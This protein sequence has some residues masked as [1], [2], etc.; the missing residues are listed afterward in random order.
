MS[1]KRPLSSGDIL[2]G[3][4]Q[5]QDMV[6]EKRGAAT[7]RATDMTLNRNVG[8]EM[9]PHSDERAAA[10]LEGARSSTRLTD[11]RFLRVL[12]IFDDE[13]GHSVVVR[14]W[15]RAFPLDQL[16]IQSPLPNRRAATVVSE[17]AEAVAHAHELGV[18]HGALSPHGVLLK[19]SGAVRVTGLGTAS[20]LA[21]VVAEP[22]TTG[23]RVAEQRDVEALGKLLYACLTG[24]WP[25]EA[26]DGLRMAPTEHG[27]LLRPRQVRAGVSRDVDA[28]CD[29]ILGSPPRNHQA[30]LSS[31]SSIA[32]TLRLAGED[33]AVL[34]DENP[35]LAGVSSPDLL[36]LDPV[37][38]PVG[39]PP[40]INPPRRRP[41]ALEPAPPTSFE[42]SKAR[43]RNATH[44]YDRTLILIG[45][46]V[47]VVLAAS[48]AFV[49]GRA[50]S[51]GEA[52][53][54][55]SGSPVR[56]LGVADV[57]DFDPFGSDGEEHPEEAKF[58][59]DDDVSTGWETSTYF[60]SAELG[61]LKPG[62]GLLFDLGGPRELTSIR[63]RLAGKPTSFQVYA[64]P[65]ET[66]DPPTDIEGLV[67]V[68]TVPE[69]GFDS[70]ITLESG[71]LARYV[72]VLLTEVPKVDEGKFRGEI[73]EVTFRG[74]S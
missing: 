29:R 58:A 56:T 54:I 62:V 45:L 46:V 32:R 37:I 68:A 18:Y 67:K 7:W 50:A 36:R 34:V 61:G 3:R 26:F 39:P 15:A 20:V 10:F 28:V 27:R 44:G 40:G 12:D 65:A 74:R 71:V 31:A 66:G 9:L 57:Q 14:E 73:R 63:V 35:S 43:A 51:D 19:Q 52:D 48:L 59:A 38:V 41:K 64:A 2:A 47:A 22:S 69:A 21:H 1:D 6:S 25:G 70:T 16:L 4:Y 33:D 55:S 11:S 42:R 13:K 5:L 72:V 60:G 53:P 30:P 8:L 49:V 24:R 23:T 17:V